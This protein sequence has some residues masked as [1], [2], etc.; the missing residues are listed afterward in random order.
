ME[1]AVGSVLHDWCI[2]SKIVD[3]YCSLDL[4]AL[5]IQYR[6]F[7]RPRKLTVAIITIV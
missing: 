2:N 5:S 6:P 7:S 4:N 3:P 1:G